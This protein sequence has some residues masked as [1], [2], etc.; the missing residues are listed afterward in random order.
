MIMKTTIF[1]LMIAAG[2]AMASA[3]PADLSAP[4]KSW[5]SAQAKIKTWSADLIETRTLQS[6]TT[7]LTS[8]GQIWFEEPDRFRWELG[9]PPETIA[10]STG[11]NLLILYPRLKRVEK[12]ALTGARNG[13]W[14]SAMEMLEAGFPRSEQDL[15]SHYDV[16]SQE[17][18]NDVIRLK[19]RPTS[20]AVRQMVPRVEIDIDAKKAILRGTQL[21]FGDG[22]TLRNDFIHVVLNPN[23]DP[24]AF[25]PA[26]PADYRVVQPMKK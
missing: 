13:Q 23:V 19:L 5:L 6:L 7:P 3:A 25:S 17:R 22:S 14:Q 16:L 26:V 15:L 12:I 4:V 2:V 1:T 18:T 11:T 20:A 8:H 21:Q 10:V 9:V 24:S